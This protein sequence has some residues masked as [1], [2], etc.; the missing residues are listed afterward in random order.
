MSDKTPAKRK[1]VYWEAPDSGLP[2]V[3]VSM[4]EQDSQP[5]N[6]AQRRQAAGDALRRRKGRRKVRGG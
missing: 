5:P 2:D 3:D 1:G 6:R 4:W